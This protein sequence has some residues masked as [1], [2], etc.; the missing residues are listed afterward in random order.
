[1]QTD[2]AGT[3]E[4]LLVDE[5]AGRDALLGDYA[6]GDLPELALWVAAARLRWRE[7]LHSGLAAA[8]ARC[9]K[10]GALARG[11]VYAQR[12]IDDDPLAEHAQRRL[13]RLHYLRGDHAAA[14]AAFERFE[15]HL[16]DELG[17]RPSTETIELLATIEQGAQQPPAPRRAIVP[18]SLLRPPRLIGRADE[19]AALEHAWAG[20]RVFALQGEAGMGK[21]RLLGDFAAGREGL[22]QVQ[23]RPGD[24]GIPYALLA[25]LMR[26]VLAHCSPSLIESRR[27]ELALL[28]PELG[29]APLVSGEA[30]R[31]MLQHGVEALLSGALTEGLGALIVDDLHFADDAS[32]EALLALTHLDAL[33]SLRWGFAQRPAEASAAARALRLAL[34]EAQ[35]LETVAVGP[36]TPTQMV[37]LIDSLRLPML[38]AARLGP[39]LMKHSGGNP[40]FALET[41]KDMVLSGAG[42]ED[43]LPQPAS[44]ATLVERRLTQLSPPA[45]KLARVAALA[46]TTF[47]AELAASVLEAH[48]L[49]IAEPWRELESAQVIRDG[50]FAHD[51]IYE[52][53]RASVPA[54]IARSL[55]RRIALHLSSRGAAPAE[56]APHWA[57]AGEWA[58]AGEAYAAAARNAQSASQRGHE[59]GH[60]HDAADAFER[61]GDPARAF[62][63]RCDAV[64]ALIVVEGVTRA[65]QVIDA[66]LAAASTDHERA[67]ALIARANA[68]LMAADHA[69]G[70]EAAGRAHELAQHLDTPWPMF[71]AARLRAV[72]LAQAGRAAE[73]LAVIEPMRALVEREG[74]SEQ[75]G[76][77]W[78]DYAYVLNAA[79]RLRATAQA[80]EYAID[81]AR[82]LGD[83]SEL[84]SLTSNLATVVGNFGHVGRALALAQRALAIQTELGATQGP[85]G[86]VVET[87]VGLYCGMVGRYREALERLDS[88]LA[89]FVRDRQPLWIAVAAN[90][91]AQLLI[92]LGQYARA[93]Q[94]LEYE[95]PPVAWVRARGAHVAARIERALGLPHAETLQR[96]LDTLTPGSDPHVRMHVLLDT[97]PRDDPHAALR[98]CDEVLGM[99]EELEFGGVAV[100]ARLQRARALS[101]AGKAPAAASA[102]RAVVAEIDEVHPADLYLGEAWWLAAEVFDAS[103]DDDDALTAL[104][105]GARWVRQ[106]ALPNV[107]EPFR[108]SFLHRNPSNR[109]LLA[110]ADRRLPTC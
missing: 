31:L 44:V 13:M 106:V 10:D 4:Q 109:L 83:L 107:P 70:I 63:A 47:D 9:E 29:S 24:A 2:L 66:L 87:Y 19:L 34:E 69:S 60:W 98:R 45:L 92:D 57:R 100:K 37:E 79:R 73:G 108:D 67:A 85:A 26:G 27:K 20:E 15:R 5:Q 101:D 22:V 65:G 76:R 103:G 75:R 36:L 99:A 46:G 56:I 90:H 80:L 84:A 32:L 95:A 82:R 21:T 64:P 68:A 18:A 11:L 23:S 41:L 102:M 6:Y 93:R 89:C 52:A 91:K 81:D 42:L 25:R 17:I 30:Q 96:A 39:V 97:L 74:D 58:S 110:A 104:A 14:I 35:R 54:A 86:A 1:V 8:A 38:D 12:L 50:A 88:A 94:A 61:S 71:D 40:L 3:L 105:R 33:Q 49:D 53:A 28:L 16:R 59:V 77:F 48:P 62:A 51:L 72:G 78:A 7:Q 43:R 55:H